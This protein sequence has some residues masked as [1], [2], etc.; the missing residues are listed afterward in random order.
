MILQ[1][2][3]RRGKIIWGTSIFFGVVASILEVASAATFSL[4]S[5]SLFGGRK[6]NF[7]ILAENLPFII[8]QTV[9]I[10]IL[11]VVFIGKLGFQWIELNL[12]TKAA[13]E[14]FTSIFRRRVS[15]SREEIEKSDSPVANMANRM[16]ILTHNIYY[17]LGLI[18]SEM[19]I[20]IFL[21]PFV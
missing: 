12:K 10:T 21:V 11:G 7:G 18:I 16:H 20:L 15:L 5:S 3:S 13:G 2:L 1:T 8:T 9:L 4:L 19:L 17:P 6:S 14:F